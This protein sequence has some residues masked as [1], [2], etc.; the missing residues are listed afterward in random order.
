MAIPSTKMTIS[1][2]ARNDAVTYEVIDVVV[3]LPEG[4]DPLGGLVGRTKLWA[5]VIEY[6]K[7]AC[8]KLSRPA[9]R[10]ADASF[11]L[12]ILTFPDFSID[13]TTKPMMIRGII[14]GISGKDLPLACLGSALRSDLILIGF[15]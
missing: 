1:K 2:P 5:G 3:K 7:Y 14:I 11:F 10:L 6:S 9:V 15:P 12:E 4:I 13:P 8:T